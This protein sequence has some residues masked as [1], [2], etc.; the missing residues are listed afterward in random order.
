MQHNHRL[1]RMGMR[2]PMPTWPSDRQD[3]DRTAVPVFLSTVVNFRPR[4]SRRAAMVVILISRLAAFRKA[5][6]RSGA[7][8]HVRDAATSRRIGGSSIG[9]IT[10]RSGETRSARSGHRGGPYGE[11]DHLD[12]GRPDAELA[13]RADSATSSVGGIRTYAH[14]CGSRTLGPMSHLCRR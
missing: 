9:R 11:V 7:S 10:R 2:T 14:R 3:R 5:R 12:G 1:P 4:A 13:P 6:A 8:W